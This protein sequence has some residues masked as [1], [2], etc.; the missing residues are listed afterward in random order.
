[1]QERSY[2]ELDLQRGRE[3]QSQFPAGQGVDKGGTV[4]C[5][6]RSQTWAGWDTW[7]MARHGGPMAQNE[8]NSG[9]V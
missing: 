3:K 4:D 6:K 5:A 7:E 2:D 9:E 1:L 8:A